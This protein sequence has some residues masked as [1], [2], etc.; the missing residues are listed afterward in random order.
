MR[1]ADIEGTTG[2]ASLGDSGAALARAE[3]AVQLARRA[4]AGEPEDLESR[5]VL[6]DA[7]FRVATTHSQRGAAEKGFPAAREAVRLT[8]TVLAADP[9][10]IERSAMAAEAIHTLAAL[11][12]RTKS[13]LPES[14]PL[15]K[16]VIEIR[17]SA[18][19][20]NPGRDLERRDL[21]RSLQFAAV[22]FIGLGDAAAAEL[23]ARESY[24]LNKTRLDAGHE[25]ARL[26]LA[27]DLGYLALLAW[28]RDDY[29]EAA[30]L[31]EEQL[32]LRRQLAA[33]EPSNSHMALGVGASMSR[34]GY[35]YAKLG[36]VKEAISIGEEALTRQREVYARDRSNVNATRE[37][38]FAF[39]DLAETYRKAGRPDHV[40][41][42][43]RESQ[44]LFSRLS[45]SST[46]MEPGPSERLAKLRLAC[47]I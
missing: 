26:Q 6:A 32:R 42:L 13:H 4:V 40:C 30:G 2:M 41:P 39:L 47:G 16:K 9:A 34:L 44:E 37:Y 15:W 11:Y 17:R 31:L 27:A 24:R 20:A 22:A 18:L 28:R 33:Q 21:A 19:A 25:R 36:R 45:K 8:E 10:N 7:L 12:T 1:L 43:V 29:K 14:I 23:H 5:T 35:T 3:R 38:F 46:P